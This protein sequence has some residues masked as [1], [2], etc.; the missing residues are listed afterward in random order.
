MLGQ[1]QEM[2]QQMEQRLASTVV[3]ATSGGGAVTV[4]MNGKK[5]VLSLKIDPTTVAGLGSNTADV[6]MLE[7]LITAALNEAGRRAD[8]SLQSGLS[9][10]LGG[11]NLPGF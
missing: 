1:A 3:E 5:Q 2:Q 7:D 4:K 6:E 9:G 10:M 8:E 11:L